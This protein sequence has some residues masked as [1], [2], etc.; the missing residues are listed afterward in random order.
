MFRQLNTE[1]LNTLLSYYQTQI[2]TIKDKKWV[3]LA[4]S[5]STCSKISQMICGELQK[6]N[7]KSIDKS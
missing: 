1:R 6:R 4:G 3:D 7:Y 5:F 2:G